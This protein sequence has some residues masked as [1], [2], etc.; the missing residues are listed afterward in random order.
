MSRLVTRGEFLTAL[1][2]S[3]AR[4]PVETLKDVRDAMRDAQ[5]ERQDSD[6]AQNYLLAAHCIEA[7]WK[8]IY[9]L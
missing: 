6:A 2:G 9:D 3:M 8:L 1:S 7:A 4:S 5:E